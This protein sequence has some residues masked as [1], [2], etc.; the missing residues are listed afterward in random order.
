[1]AF[2]GVMVLAY[3]VV[4]LF[5]AGLYLAGGDCINAAVPGS[6][7]EAFSFSV[8]T[9]STIGYGTLSPTTPWAH[10][11]MVVESF[12][13]LIGV[14]IATGLCFA[15]FSR[16]QARVAFS[17]VAVVSMRS[18]RPC[19]SFRMA[20]ERAS[21]II[22]AH[23]QVYVLLDEQ[24]PEGE[25]MRRFHPITLERDRS[26]MF[27]LS[28]TVLHFMDADSPLAG[29]TAHNIEEHMVSLVVILTG[30]EAAFVQNVHAQH[31]YVPDDIRFGMRFADILEEQDGLLIV[32]HERLHDTIP[33]PHG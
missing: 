28:W 1:M 30:V 9:L 18:G 22:D 3:A 31:F 24:T 20:N 14:A 12:V 29:M 13:G 32:H 27:T 2:F 10:A 16:P 4:N 11:V 33:D 8:Q 15:K 25:R 23:L 19:L 5:F 6:F 21:R 26:P 17:D 7:V